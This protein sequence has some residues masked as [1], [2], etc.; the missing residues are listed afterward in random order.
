MTNMMVKKRDNSLEEFDVENIRNSITN[1]YFSINGNLHN[2]DKNTTMI[3]DDIVKITE[4]ECTLLED[5]TTTDIRNIVIDNLMQQQT[6][7]FYQT[8][9]SYQDYRFKDL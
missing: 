3:I 9:I 2:Y 4:E 6:P 7:A 8:A 1:A 5:L